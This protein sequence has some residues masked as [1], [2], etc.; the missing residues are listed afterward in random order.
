MNDKKGYEVLAHAFKLEG[1]DTVFALLGD[2]NMYWGYALAKQQGV[3]VIHAR[4]EHGACAMAE[5]YARKT[6]NVGVATVTSGPGF[7]QIATALAIAARG[8]VPMVVFAGD[9]STN[10]TF[11]AQAFDLGPLAAATGA[12]YVP[13]KSIDR[14]LDNVREAFYVAQYEQRPVVLGVPMNFQ[15]QAFPWGFDYTPSTNLVPRS[16]RLMPD[17]AIV[18]E[19][20]SM[21]IDAERP[22]ILAGRGALRS[23]A[24]A[25]LEAI[26]EQSGALLATSLFAKGLF[27]HSPYGIGIAGSFASPL[28]REEF[29][30]C[31]LLIGVGAG[32][33]F[34]TTEA[35][36]LCPNARTVQIDINPKGLW[37]GLRTADLHLKSDAMTASEA[38]AN[39]LRKRRV[40]KQ[41]ARTAELAAKIAIENPDP[42]QFLPEAG[43]IDPRKA[44]LELDQIIPKDWDI[45]VGGAHF[46]SIVL[47]HMRGRA[48]ERYHVINDFAAIG[49]A[50]SAA[51]GI[52]T[53]RT[54]GKVILFEGDGSLLMHIQELETAKRHGLRLLI[55][56]M[57]DG[58]YGAELHK[59]RAAKMDPSEVIFGRPDLAAIARGFGL[60]GSTVSTSGK[61]KFTELLRGYEA[62]DTTELWDLQISDKI[63]SASYRRVWFGEV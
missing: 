41:G 25:A 46:F 26:A 22:I 45:V 10:A 42:K 36:Y 43:V 40:S 32:L 28:A 50:M 58:G 54:D 29:A 62:A 59:F 9:S 31:D 53:T 37:Q 8:Y 33:G 52:A 21:I 51:I 63:P 14:M 61:D 17:P 1:V 7:T 30:A 23:G 47:T 35:G 24:T 34:Y 13:V 3:R 11:A 44:I 27:D 18:D 55:C 19:V 56:A 49:S 60:R 2:A 38:I 4:H 16:Q 6:G 12:Y 57:N 48:A 5:G 15:S 39:E 20:V